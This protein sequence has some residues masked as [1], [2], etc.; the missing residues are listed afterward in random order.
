MFI[1]EKWGKRNLWGEWDKKV[2]DK[3]IIRSMMLNI[4]LRHGV[5]FLENMSDPFSFYTD[6]SYDAAHLD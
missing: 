5:G 1:F 4:G 2:F 3:W 6:I